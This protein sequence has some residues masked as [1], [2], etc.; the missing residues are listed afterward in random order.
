MKINHHDFRQ[1][2]LSLDQDEY[3]ILVA[4]DAHGPKSMH[5]AI[6]VYVVNGR[7][8]SKRGKLYRVNSLV[9]EYGGK[10]LQKSVFLLP[11]NVNAV[12]DVITTLGDIEKKYQGEVSVYIF[13]VKKEHVG[14]VNE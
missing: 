11:C 13:P 5:S 6:S 12:K 14:D 7:V 2:I 10:V 9:D 4:V 3:Y 1:L 8:V